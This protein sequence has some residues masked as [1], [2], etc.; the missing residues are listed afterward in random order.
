MSTTEDV[1]DHRKDEHTSIAQR[2]PVHVHHGWV[3][4]NWEKGENPAEKQKYNSDRVDNETSLA[5][6]ELGWQ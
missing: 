5:Q 1:V 3:R 4:P 6:I 2:C